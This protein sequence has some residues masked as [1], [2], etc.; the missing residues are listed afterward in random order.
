[1]KSTSFLLG[2]LLIPFFVIAQKSKKDTAKHV[3][4]D[5]MTVTAPAGP[6]PFQYSAP[7]IWEISHTQIALSFDMLEKTAK[8]RE[9]VKLRPYFYAT[10]TLVLDAKGLRIDSVELVTKTGRQSLRYSYNDDQLT[11]RFTGKYTRTDSLELFFKYTAMPYALPTGGSAAISDDRGL[12]FINT[13]H[14]SPNKPA[15]I[16]TQGETESNSHWMIT[17]DKPNTRFT[18]QVEL[19]IPD[20]LTT[21]SNGALVK[22]IK[23]AG[24][25]RTDIWRM[26]LP[27]Q[28]YAVMFAISNYSVV[29][30]HWRNK[31]VSYYVEPAYA[32]YANLMFRNTPD[33]MEYFSQRT[34]VPYPWNK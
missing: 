33:M 22:Q 23:G 12:Y 11:I 13:D 30:D 24:K 1:M 16:W 10:D 5:T 2:F 15:H 21:L 29:K 19:T 3:T 8:V 32:R 18:T 28:P 9:W 25:M 31:E 17:I 7:K 34:G 27:I 26:D 4:L 14:K 6:R 20:S